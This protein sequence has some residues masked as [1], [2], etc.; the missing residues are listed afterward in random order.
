M[1]AHLFS[2]FIFYSFL[3]NSGV[4]TTDTEIE[5]DN[6]AG[7]SNSDDNDVTCWPNAIDSP[8]CWWV[9]V[10]LFLLLLLLCCLF[11]FCC[12]RS[13]RPRIFIRLHQSGK[14]GKTKADETLYTIYVPSTD[15]PM[16]DLVKKICNH[17]DVPS[18]IV[19]GLK[20]DQALGLYHG[21]TACVLDGDTFLSDY[22]VFP[23]KSNTAPGRHKKE[24]LLRFEQAVLDI[25]VS[26][27]ANP[28]GQYSPR[29]KISMMSRNVHLQKSV[30]MIA[31]D[32][33]KNTP[34]IALFKRTSMD[35]SAS[36]A[37]A[38][39]AEKIIDV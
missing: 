2:D 5:A 19:N 10:L 33:D 37:V 29:T 31:I 20:S 16:S 6:N 35:T 30:E 18:Q 11:L 21:T 14:L 13:Q 22:S 1:N 4:P 27:V 3:S 28:M 32:F 25:R 12:W 8:W 38:L 7:S 34:S 39:A 17:K 9:W 26:Y 24:K 36:P 23:L 15:M